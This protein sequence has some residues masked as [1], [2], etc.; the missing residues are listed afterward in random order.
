MEAHPVMK[1]SGE[2]FPLSVYSIIEEKAKRIPDCPAISAPGH[3][4][5]CYLRLFKQV[6]YTVGRLKTMGLRR[7]D[8]IAI[9][10]PN[11]PKMATA[12]LSVTSYATAVP[13]NTSFS[14]TEFEF[15]LT[16][17]N[18]KALIVDS[19]SNIAAKDAADKYNIPII[20]LSS[21]NE[22][23]AGI[24]DLSCVKLFPKK[25]YDG[26]SQKEDIALILYT[27]GTTSRPKTVPLTH[28]NI[29]TSAIRIKHTLNLI[30][31]DRCLNIMPLFH[32]HGLIG[33][34]LSSICAGSSIVCTPGYY[35]T[36]FFKWLDDFKPTWFT[37][38]P[39]MHQGILSR[40]KDHIDIIRNN[41]MRFIRSC[42]AALPPSVLHEVEL[43]FNVPVIESYGMTESSHEI[44]SNP[45]PPAKRKAGSVGIPSGSEIAVM[46]ESGKI[47]P[48]S[49]TG[50]IVIRGP[51]VTRGYESHKEANE[52]SFTNGWF[53][54]GDQG[55]L[56]PEGYLFLTG[57][58]KEII[59]RGGEKISPFEIDSVLLRHPA[60]EQAVAFALE[61]PTLGEEVAAAV[62]L[63][64]GETISQ[65]EL[66]EFAERYLASFK[67]PNQIFF[68]HKI[69]K[70]PTGKVQR[71]KLG[72]QMKG[73]MEKKPALKKTSPGFPTRSVSQKALLGIWKEV[74]G[75]D[76]IDPNVDFFMAGGDSIQAAQILARVKVTL[77]VELP[78]S[79]FLH[80]PYVDKMAGIIASVQKAN[81]KKGITNASALTSQYDLKS[82]H[83]PFPL[84]DIQQA[85]WAG[86]SGDYELGGVSTHS[87]FEVD[88]V[89]LDL[90]RFARALN[91]MIRRHGML[92]AV[93]NSDGYQRIQ[94]RVPEYQIHNDDFRC[95]SEVRA[96]ARLLSTR[97]QMSHQILPSTQWPLFEV[98]AS[99]IDMQRTRLHFSIDGL[100]MDAWS[101]DIFFSEL[102]LIYKQ[103]NIR[104]A[105]EDFTFR[106]Y[107]V[108]LEASR[109]SQ[110]YRRSMQYWRDRF[111]SLPFAPQL[112]VTRDGR[113]QMQ[114]QFKRL[115]AKISRREWQQLKKRSRKTKLTPAGL[116]LAAFAEIISLWSQTSRFLLNVPHFNRHQIHPQVNG[117]IGQFASL[118]FLEIDTS[119]GET[120]QEHAGRVQKQLWAD[121]EH[122]AT[123][124]VAVLR[125][126]SRHWNQTGKTVLPVVFTSA[127]HGLQDR[128]APTLQ[129]LGDLAYS[130][131][132]TP[133]VWLDCQVHEENGALVIDWNWIAG[134][135][136]EGVA[137]NMF[138][139]YSRLLSLLHKNASA[140]QQHR[141]QLVRF[142][143]PDEQLEQREKVNAT[144]IKWPGSLLHEQFC[145]QTER[146]PKH[147][148][149]IDTRRTISYG[150][151]LQVANQIA[152]EI[153]TWDL[154]PDAL[155]AVE[156]QKGW[157][158]VAAVMGILMAGAAYIP[159]DPDQPERRIRYIYKDACVKG[160]LKQSWSAQK[161][162]P[163][164][165]LRT[166]FV[167][168]LPDDSTQAPSPLS[169]QPPSEVA[170]LI[171]T[172]GSTGHPKGVV[173]PHRA[174]TNVIRYT[175]Q[176]FSLRAEDRILALTPLFHDMSFYDL[177]G[178]LSSG[179]TIVF[180]DPDL[181]KDPAHWVDLIHRHKVTL[182]NSVP[183]M[184]QMLLEYLGEHDQRAHPS[185]RL[186]FVGGETVNPE[187]ADRFTAIFDNASLVSVGGPT[188]TT[189]WNIMHPINPSDFRKKR[190]PYGKPISN[191]QYYVLNQA[192][193]DRPVW[194]T[195]E[196]YC[197]GIGLAKGYW[198]DEEKTDS[199]F[200]QHPD[201]GQKLYKTGDIGRYLPD[202][203]IEILGRT[204]FQLKIRGYRIEAGEI[205]YALSRHPWVQ[206]SIVKSLADADGED[207]LV[208]YVTLKPVA[209]REVDIS[210]LLKFLHQRL[211]QEMVPSSIFLLDRLPR[212]PNGKIDRNRL[213][214]PTMESRLSM[215]ESIP[216]ED[217]VVG[218][219]TAIVS[220]VLKIDFL[221][222]DVNWFSLGATSIDIIRILNRLEAGLYFRPRIDQV[223]DMPSISGMAKA[224]RQNRT[225]DQDFE[226]AHEPIPEA[227]S[228]KVRMIKDP[229]ERERFRTSQPA[230][231][232][233][234]ERSSVQLVNDMSNQDSAIERYSKRRSYRHFVKK[235]IAFDRFSEFIGCLRQMSVNGNSKYLYPSAGGLYSV[236]AYLFIKQGRIQGISPGTYYYHPIDHRLYHLKI[237][238]KLDRRIYGRLYNRAI[239]DEAAFAIFLVVE[240]S[241]ILPLYGTNSIHLATL[242]CGYMGQL[243][244]SMAV[245]QEIGLC[246]IGSLNFTP[247]RHLFTLH[248]GQ[249]LL[250]SLLSGRIQSNV[251]GGCLQVPGQLEAFEEGEI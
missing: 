51:C 239:F 210:E 89:D 171:Y 205:E 73:Q 235:P 218:R 84:N 48:A 106:D 245:E 186:A 217:D 161:S 71:L 130:I 206:T 86:R 160:A 117:I 74:M 83:D 46:D 246:A 212:L 118:T 159:V 94:E 7:N 29:C 110:P 9:A 174:V 226:P 227:Y 244:S 36:K 13:L 19:K 44:A 222:P 124:G 163:S 79:V 169:V 1:T 166:L 133:Q 175:N 76:D 35:I 14:P 150:E 167:D 230:I 229:I 168:T 247:V 16:D 184:L 97:K 172:S 20:E 157:E 8:R 103:P 142:L 18:A 137:E 240:L 201:T 111:D 67:I 192:M 236:Q 15:Y 224:Y 189:L 158:Q 112:P 140:W 92:R 90:M 27:S 75:L 37:A 121:L 228:S 54:T 185:I 138:K 194:V 179:A 182:W 125:E 55:Y 183:T 102:F 129:T 72:V 66:Q 154:P 50:E 23:E 56:D 188:E 69:P 21:T 225:V 34:L 249:I 139:A 5:L 70:G 80:S 59:N 38:V 141:R 32:I 193:E 33:A 151:L 43:V 99:L 87:Y 128:S 170:C 143:I 6:V 251:R 126:L 187:L 153:Q 65:S 60:V 144:Q 114:P 135:F 234:Q 12:F 52:T 42:S 25:A 180:P 113:T 191:S 149:V 91:L 119:N 63:S 219:I 123:G 120:F 233:M 116:L 248:E 213:P 231:R 41:R 232:S 47:L 241:T 156:M 28:K 200:I 220:D 82:R 238:A 146:A 49:H 61:H 10:L 109:G 211:P 215:S 242:D 127:P 178:I 197:S 2:S 173:I 164:G 203:N 77:G 95:L 243:L 53:R 62:V 134:L 176:R 78:F 30:Q 93:I 152:V 132:Q 190:I 181:R 88:C 221:D 45:V 24:F 145:E 214:L 58:I 85:Y 204:D 68:V 104:I 198:M 115:T 4:P 216:H 101:R 148:A 131:S 40:S 162:L 196:L 31:E 105:P 3:T 107:A 195:G 136:R 17:I 223:Y 57:R 177:F 39:T 155:I 165:P 208:A 122:G 11:G 199:V 209:E 100:I 22:S 96:T 108:T 202:G 147:P 237:G 64:D 207:R 26:F 250:H 98:R 81:K